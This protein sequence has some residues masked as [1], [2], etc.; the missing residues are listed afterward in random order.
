MFDS[1]E[2][3]DVFKQLISSATKSIETL[4]DVRK[5]HPMMASISRHSIAMNVHLKTLDLGDP[6]SIRALT[7]F[8][9]FSTMTVK[10]SSGQLSNA[11]TCLLILLGRSL[12]LQIRM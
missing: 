9:S 5:S 7:F 1:T 4:C 12:S 11:P 2:L 10:G 6:E 8:P 3:T